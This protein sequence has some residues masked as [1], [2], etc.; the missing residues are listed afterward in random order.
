MTL[1]DTIENEAEIIGE[2]S[3]PKAKLTTPSPSSWFLS[4]FS[5]SKTTITLDLNKADLIEAYQTNK[6]I[7]L[8]YQL[9][10]KGKKNRNSQKLVSTE[11][12]HTINDKNKEKKYSSKITLNHETKK[13]LVPVSS[14]P[15]DTDKVVDKSTG[16]SKVENMTPMVT[17]EMPKQTEPNVPDSTLPMQPELP[18]ETGK[19][20]NNVETESPK[21]IENS[22][23]D[24]A[25]KPDS[26]IP[27]A[28]DNIII[29]NSTFPMKPE[30]PKEIGETENSVKPESPKPIED[31]DSSAGTQ[32]LDIPKV[33]DT[34]DLSRPMKPESTEEI[35][36]AE[37][38]DTPDSSK[39]I[40]DSDNSAPISTIKDKVNAET[41][42]NQVELAMNQ[43]SRLSDNVE[44]VS[45]VNRSTEKSNSLP[46]TG[47]ADSP[48]YTLT[49]LSLLVEAQVLYRTKRKQESK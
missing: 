18:K 35:G 33:M 4:L 30:S 26:T 25:N 14:E 1:V 40:K 10:Y 34:P 27:K 49:A 8:T 13:V 38:S 24:S 7:S 11:I 28:T 5:S 42:A 17:P 15:K 44:K 19:T 36:K 45:S 16:I 32:K 21:P 31:T 46:S 29:P 41:V 37:N 48:I 12:S 3:H 9:K 20:G 43:K 22:T 47:Q 2:L 39:T 6:P 23:D